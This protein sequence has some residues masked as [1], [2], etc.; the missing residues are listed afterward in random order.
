MSQEFLTTFSEEAGGVLL[1]PSDV[2]GRYTISIGNEIVFD[3]K[4]HGG[5]ADI[6]ELKMLIRDVI[7][8]GKSLGHSERN[9][10]EE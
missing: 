3:R 9:T 10:H 4:Q 1:K 2:S 8:P 5:F 6:K 7:A